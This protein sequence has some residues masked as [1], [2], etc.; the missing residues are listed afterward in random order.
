MTEKWVMD[1]NYE[2]ETIEVPEKPKR[3][4]NEV[5]KPKITKKGKDPQFSVEGYCPCGRQSGTKHSY[6]REP[7]YCSRYCFEF[8]TFP[9]EGYK[10]KTRYDFWRG[11]G[12]YSYNPAWPK[13]ESN[14]EWC[15]EVFPLTRAEKDSNRLF[16]GLECRNQA[17]RNAKGTSTRNGSTQIGLRVRTM[18]I[19]RAFSD[20]EMSADEIA[21]YYRNWF[22]LSCSSAKIAS[23]IKTLI[24]YDWVRKIEQP[25]D[26]A[27]FYQVVDTKSPLKSLFGEEV[28]LPN[29]R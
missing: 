12:K 4:P 19:L 22:R 13:L 9:A 15:A 28:I 23:S 6:R 27:S 1:N 29:R 3:R 21:E 7:R 14:C 11:T 18:M 25:A 26:K 10:R 17:I 24:K 20:K 16:C 8:M 2:W 5:T